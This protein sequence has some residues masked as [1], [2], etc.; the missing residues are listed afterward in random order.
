MDGVTLVEVRNTSNCSPKYVVFYFFF[1]II[2]FA[3]FIQFLFHIRF[4][5][6]QTLIQPGESIFSECFMWKKDLCLKMW[7]HRFGILDCKVISMSLDYVSFFLV[8]RWHNCNKGAEKGK[9]KTR[10]LLRLSGNSVHKW[11]LVQS[12]SDLRPQKMYNSN[13]ASLS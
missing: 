3:C 7:G 5:T 9:W 6:W 12:L 4:L 8:C 10:Y 2:F 13:M 11:F 1:L